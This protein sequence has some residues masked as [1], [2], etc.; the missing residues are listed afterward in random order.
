VLAIPDDDEIAE[1]AEES[2][3]LLELPE[4]NPVNVRVNE[5]VREIM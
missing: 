1:F 5:F 3:S 2:R 4:D